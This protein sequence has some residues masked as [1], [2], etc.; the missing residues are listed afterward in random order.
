MQQTN[1]TGWSAERIAQLL[2]SETSSGF[3]LQ[4]G[5]LFRARLVVVDI[6][7]HLLV[8]TAHHLVADGWSFKII[9]EEICALYALLCGEA[10]AGPAPLKVPYSTLALQ[11]E[12]ASELRERQTRAWAERLS[13][14]PLSVELHGRRRL[15]RSPDSGRLRE[16]M[17]AAGATRI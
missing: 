10:T 6:N 7:E 1:A 8:L 12:R 13:G 11:R 3:D 17:S 4:S 2:R 16:P 15:D 5:P 14:A 9:F